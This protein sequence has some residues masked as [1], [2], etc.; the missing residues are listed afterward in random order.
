M[1]FLIS[2]RRKFA[3]TKL[4]ASLRKSFFAVHQDQ[5]S[6]EEIEQ[7]VDHVSQGAF[8]LSS[9]EIQKCIGFD[10]E[11]LIKAGVPVHRFGTAR[12]ESASS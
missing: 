4:Q 12:K 1:V 6:R 10:P 11:E 7:L 3:G 5:P 2:Y 9:I 8:A